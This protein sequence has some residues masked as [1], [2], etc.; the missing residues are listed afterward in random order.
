MNNVSLLFPE[1]YC[2]FENLPINNKEL[3]K[4]LE[5]IEYNKT[6]TSKGCYTSSTVSYTDLTLPTTPYV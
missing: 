3:T 6:L 4:L 1:Y 5:G 2:H